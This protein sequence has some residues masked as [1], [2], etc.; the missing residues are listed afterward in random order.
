V[1]INPSKANE[2][3][4]DF[5]SLFREAKIR[6]FNF[7]EINKIICG[8][9]LKVMKEI[10]DNSVDLV[11]TDPPYMISRKEKYSGLDWMGKRSK[12]GVNVNFDFGEWDYFDSLEDYLKFTKKWF[13]ECY[14]L[15]RDGG[16]IYSF[17][18]KERQWFLWKWWEEFGGKSRNIIT[19]HKLNPIPQVRKVG[20]QSSTEFAFWGTK[21]KNHT[22]NYQLGQC[23]NF[24]ETSIC[25]GNE[26]WT[27]PTQ[28][29]L[30]V[31]E[32][33]LSY[34]SNEN[35]IILDPFL[36][37]GTTAV[38][39]KRLKRNYIGIE[40]SEKYCDIARQRIKGQAKPML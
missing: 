23:H 40:I 12:D 11:L 37:S 3:I 15:I 9:C 19:W 1:L 21:G 34:S 20:Y 33:F 6:N 39:C 18:S 16:Q 38:A 36:G 2:L 13:E 35:D 32:M 24:I 28:K 4:F 7:M 8:N 31:I 27:H 5:V 30:K 10:P 14:R 29:S 22:F 17:F 25:S 26:R